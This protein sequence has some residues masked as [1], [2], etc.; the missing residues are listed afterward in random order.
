MTHFAALLSRAAVSL[1]DAGQVNTYLDDVMAVGPDEVRQAAATWLS[2]EVM[3][4]LRYRRAGARA[5][6]VPRAATAQGAAA[7]PAGE[8]P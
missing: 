8:L 7:H 3:S 6:G 1:G 4:T 2:P 5:G